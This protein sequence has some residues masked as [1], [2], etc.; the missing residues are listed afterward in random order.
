MLNEPCTIAE[1]WREGRRLVAIR[2]TAAEE[3]DRK[4]R[5]RKLSRRLVRKYAV[6]VVA[7]FLGGIPRRTIRDA[8]GIGWNTLCKIIRDGTTPGQRD[9]IRRMHNARRQREWSRIRKG[10]KAHRVPRIGIVVGKTSFPS[11][12]AAARSLNFPISSAHAKHRA[13]IPAARWKEKTKGWRSKKV[14]ACKTQS[15]T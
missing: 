13:G 12:T 10:V 7:D 6:R 11:I 9:E 5:K 14:T 8:Y 1:R 15:T 4:G 3:M 2:R